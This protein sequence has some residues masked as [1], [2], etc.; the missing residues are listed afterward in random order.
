MLNG[1]CERG[2]IFLNES[3]KMQLRCYAEAVVDFG[4]TSTNFSYVAGF[5]VIAELAYGQSRRVKGQCLVSMSGKRPL[6]AKFQQDQERGF[7]VQARRN[8]L[9][10]MWA[11]EKLG[12]TGG[13]ADVYA[14]DV[15]SAEFRETGD[16]DV[17]QKVSVDLKSKGI[18]VSDHILRVAGGDGS[19]VGDCA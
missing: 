13:D 12:L 9:F 4:A 5:P 19:F 8:F 15:V 3:G 14:K 1:A 18:A 11:A 2:A 6:R 17:L 16:Q 7:K 10:G